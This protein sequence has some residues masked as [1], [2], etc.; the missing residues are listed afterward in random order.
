[1]TRT[2]AA[3]ILTVLM[4]AVV[5]W[6]VA[7]TV[8]TWPGLVVALQQQAPEGTNVM[9]ISLG[10]SALVL[11]AAAAIWIFADVLARLALARPGQPPFESDMAPAQWQEVAFAVVGLW[12][13]ATGL[14]GMATQGLLFLVFRNVGSFE[15]Y[16]AGQF[17][18]DLIYD[19]M[20]FVVGLVLLLQARGLVGVLRKLR[21]HDRLELPPPA[22]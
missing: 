13:T 3:G 2:N 11:V 16:F 14:A 20:S 10:A 9:G 4:R 8:T 21:G 1:M 5:L 7:R 12:F 17:G 22:E 15:A 19:T 18:Q 6:M